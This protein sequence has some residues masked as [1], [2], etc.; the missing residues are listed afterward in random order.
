MGELSDKVIMNNL[1]GYFQ[2][3]SLSAFETF[4]SLLK[5]RL[6]DSK[7]QLIAC[8]SSQGQLTE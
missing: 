2:R 5:N 6:F 3:K 1:L 4:S 8:A 7:K